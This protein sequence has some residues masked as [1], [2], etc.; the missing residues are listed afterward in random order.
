MTKELTME[1]LNIINKFWNTNNSFITIKSYYMN[2]EITNKYINYRLGEKNKNLICNLFYIKT[3]IPIIYNTNEN[4]YE[5]IENK[6]IQKIFFIFVFNIYDSIPNRKYEGRFRIYNTELKDYTY[7]YWENIPLNKLSF[8][9]IRTLINYRM[10]SGE[11]IIIVGYKPYSLEQIKNI[12][13]LDST[14]LILEK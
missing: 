5:L 8:N 7:I 13:S 9:I 12:L 4:E 6:E 10:F 3:N 1:K 14:N 2:E 11:Y